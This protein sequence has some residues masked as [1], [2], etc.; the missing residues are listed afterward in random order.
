MSAPYLTQ[1]L[2]GQHN[3]T[4]FYSGEPSI[5]HYLKTQAGQDSKRKFSTCYVHV[6]EQ[7]IVLGYYTVSAY[8]VSR[9]DLTDSITQKWPPAYHQIPCILIGRFGLDKSVQGKGFGKVLLIDALRRCVD[10]SDSLG[11]VAIVIHPLNDEIR[12]FYTKLGFI[13]FQDKP[14]QFIAVKTVKA[15]F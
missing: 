14:F 13:S 8:S 12:K 6:D 4:R 1:K 7:Q 2:L 10:I 3:R 9:L 5:D 11:A 15:L